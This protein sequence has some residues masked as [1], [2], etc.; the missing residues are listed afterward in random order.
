MMMTTSAKMTIY[1]SNLDVM[2]RK[3]KKHIKI[4]HASWILLFLLLN[5]GDVTVMLAPYDCLNLKGI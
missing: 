2:K 5:K 1:V 4:K 3:K